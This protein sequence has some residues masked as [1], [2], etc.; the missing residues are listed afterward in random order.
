[1]HCISSRALIEHPF[2]PHNTPTPHTHTLHTHTLPTHHTLHTHTTHTPHTHTP[3]THTLHTH[4]THTHTHT[5]HPHHTHT[6]GLLTIAP[7]VTVPEEATNNVIIVEINGFNLYTVNYNFTN[8]R[9]LKYTSGFECDVNW[10]WMTLYKPDCVS[11]TITNCMLSIHGQL[12]AHAIRNRNNLGFE[13]DNGRSSLF[14]L[15]L[16]FTLDNRRLFREATADA[17][18]VYCENNEC[19]VAYPQARTRWIDSRVYRGIAW[20]HAQMN[21][22]TR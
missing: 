6:E 21:N 12:H 18:N 13:P 8:Y 5:L 22:S 19:L 14:I 15:S 2:Y 20:N 11:I 3:H 7:P 4:H 1:M 9:H 16:Q 17:I 10:L